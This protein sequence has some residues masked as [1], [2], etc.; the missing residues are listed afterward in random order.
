[1]NAQIVF[2]HLL[3]AIASV[4]MFGSS[5]IGQSS[6]A[7]AKPEPSTPARPFAVF[8]AQSL[9]ELRQ[10]L[11]AQGNINE[12]LVA[13]EGLQLRVAVQHS[14][15][16]PAPGG[17]VHDRADDIYYVLEGSATLTIGGKLEQPRQIQP[18][19]WRG[20]RIVGGQIVQAERGD[21]IIVPRGTPHQ[22]S[23][24]GQDYT[25][26]LIKV[27]AEPAQPPKR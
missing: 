24:I 15:D 27:F 3:V 26:I 5:V 7:K 14:K 6:G 21:L 20:P 16:E 23:T 10:R 1:M 8:K 13:G 17:E 12:D 11:K 25:I 2:K 19:E 9:A 18:G 4:C 22:R